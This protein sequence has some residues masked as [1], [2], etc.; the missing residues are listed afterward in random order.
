MHELNDNSRDLGNHD[1]SIIG[2][3]SELPTLDFDNGTALCC[4]APCSAFTTEV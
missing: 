1:I 4:L 2:E 3:Y